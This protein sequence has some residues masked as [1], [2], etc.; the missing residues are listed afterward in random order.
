MASNTE[1]AKTLRQFL[2]AKPICAVFE[3]RDLTVLQALPVFQRIYPPHT[4]VI[5]QGDWARCVHVINNGWGCVYRDLPDGDRQILDFPMRGDFIGLRT[6]LGF[7]YNTVVAV[8][9]LSMLE[10]SMDILT[11]S[12]LKSPRLAMTFMELIA[13]Q[14]AVLI[15]HLINVGRRSAFVRVVHLLLELG[16]RARTN[17]IGTETSFL[18]PLTQTELAD[19]L[20]LTPIHINRMLRELREQNLLVFKNNEVEFIDRAALVHASNFDEHYLTM[21]IFPKVRMVP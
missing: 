8:T 6:G 13:R 15:E 19:A 7:N 16:H 9:E 20:G 3:E 1:A 10:V 18:C 14:R 11:E 17:G 2:E 5:N 4:V 12:L 21:E